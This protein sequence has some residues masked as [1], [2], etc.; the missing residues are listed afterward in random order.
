MHET[1]LVEFTLNAVEKKAQEIGFQKVSVI[2]IVIGDMRGALPDLMEQAFRLLKRRR[3]LFQDCRLEMAQISVKL[4]C[5][6]CGTA[7]EPDDFHPSE[8]GSILAAETI[9]RVIE[10]AER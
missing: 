7:Y 8:A 5:A 1:S 6:Y 2:R 3:P 9:A 10:E 4:R